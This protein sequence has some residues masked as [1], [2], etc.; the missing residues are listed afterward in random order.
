MAGDVAA[1]LPLRAATL[2]LRGNPPASPGRRAASSL[3]ARRSEVGGQRS[4]AG[5]GLPSPTRGLGHRRARQ[6]TSVRGRLL[7]KGRTYQAA[8][9][10][11]Q[12]EGPLHRPRVRVF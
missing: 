12:D 11:R 2:G 9:G 8:G 3:P 7:S 4:A 10:K 1:A 5:W 6:P